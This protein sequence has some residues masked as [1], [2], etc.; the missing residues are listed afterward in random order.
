MKLKFRTRSAP[1]FPVKTVTIPLGKRVVPKLQMVQAPYSFRGG[2]CA[3]KIKTGL[4]NQ[5]LHIMIMSFDERLRT[6]VVITNRTDKP[7]TLF[8]EN[9]IGL[10]DKRMPGY[11]VELRETIENVVVGQ[12]AS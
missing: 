6:E 1:L 7:Y 11:F 2:T 5:I 3:V 4:K 10:A 9:R 12:I 8:K